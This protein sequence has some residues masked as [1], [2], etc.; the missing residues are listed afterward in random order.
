MISILFIII[1]IWQKYFFCVLLFVKKILQCTKFHNKKIKNHGN[2]ILLQIL[3]RTTEQKAN[4]NKK[5]QDAQASASD[6]IFSLYGLR[7]YSNVKIEN[8]IYL[9]K[10][11]SIKKPILVI[12][13]LTDIW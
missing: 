6:W 13:Q 12:R 2:V 10:L 9:L 5:K 7:C 8:G 3:S 11:F 4:H 1:L